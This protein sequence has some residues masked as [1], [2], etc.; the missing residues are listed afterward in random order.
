MAAGKEKI[1]LGRC[2]SM[3]TAYGEFK[4]ISLGPE[5]LQKLNDFAKTNSG[6]AN[7]LIK[8]KKT[9]GPGETNF[10]VEMDTWVSDGKPKEKL[11]F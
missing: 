6:W 11:P 8:N 5:D 9:A 10:Y 4:K 2:F 7:L 3:K 1:Y